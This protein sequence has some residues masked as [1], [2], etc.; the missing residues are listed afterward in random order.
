MSFKMRKILLLVA[1][2]FAT[3][4]AA[5]AQTTE[6]NC[7]GSLTVTIQGATSGSPLAIDSAVPTRVDCNGALGSIDLTVSGGSS[8]TGNAGEA[9]EYTYSW[10]GPNG[11][12]STVQDPTG[13]EPGLYTVVVTDGQNCMVDE[14]DIEILPALAEPVLASSSVTPADCFE[15][16]NGEIDVTVTIPTGA[17]NVVYSWSGPNGFTASTEDL[18]GLAA[19]DYVLT[20]SGDDMCPKTFDPITVT[21]PAVLAVALDAAASN[22][23]LNCNG[24]ADGSLSID[25]TGGNGGFTFAWTGPNSYSSTDED[26][27][28]LSAGTYQVVVTDSKNCTVTSAEFVITENDAVAF[29]SSSVNPDCDPLSGSITINNPT[30]G[31]GTYTYA[32]YTLDAIG[33]TATAFTSN[34]SSQSQPA[35]DPGFYRVVVSDGNGCTAEQDFELEA[36]ETVVASEGTVTQPLCFGDSNGSFT[37]TAQTGD[38]SDEPAG[39]YTYILLDAT[40]NETATTNT[41]GSFTNLA[42]GSYTVRA[43]NNDTNCFGDVTVVLTEPDAL[44]AGTCTN[45]QDYCDTG[46]GEIKVQ[47]SGGT[48]PYTVTYLDSN[49]SDSSLSVGS[50][51]GD[52]SEV[53]FTG[54]AAGVTYTFKVTDAN[55]CMIGG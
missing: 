45:A 13:L 6:E 34:G 23:D 16:S 26:I 5:L 30:G 40:G 11:F 3:Y 18:T 46:A 55:G 42:A 12:T 14:M 44:T 2:I 21:E 15:D 49:G 24:D 27:T 38:G 43:R 22:T 9:G 29:T 33:G 39:G 53:T 4:T 19:G 20:V 1:C 35:L 54:A 50:S 8:T 32:W 37:V 51:N 17:T 47:S 10:T 41:D 31:D 48:G 36:P 28:G 25:V 7:E 52:N